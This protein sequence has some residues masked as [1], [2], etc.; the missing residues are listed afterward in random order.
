MSTWQHDRSPGFTL[1]EVLVAMTIV[2]VALL[3]ALRVATQGTNDAAELHARLLAGWVA[4]DRL[5]EHRVRG[6]WLD[7]GVQTGTQYQGK[8][9]FGWREEVSTTPNAAFRRV[10]T[11]V[12]LPDQATHDLAHTVGL[13]VNPAGG[14]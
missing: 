4:A 2:A 1:V 7:V 9:Q 10:D 6:D 3:A 12:F 14:P 8:L 13:I 11:Y 5:A